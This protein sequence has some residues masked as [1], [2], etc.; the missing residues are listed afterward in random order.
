[1]PNDFY[2]LKTK[3]SFMLVM[4]EVERNPN[5]HL[6]N[7]RLRSQRSYRNVITI[8]AKMDRKQKQKQQIIFRTRL[9]SNLQTK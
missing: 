4:K 6:Q 8:K 1:M 7:L 2:L 5:L 3:V 9:C